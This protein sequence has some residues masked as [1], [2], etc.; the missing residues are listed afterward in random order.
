MHKD[1]KEY[2]TKEKHEALSKELDNLRTKGRK[3]IAEALE[4]AKS[5]G[6]LSENAE[7]QEARATQAEI[8]ERIAKLESILKEAVIVKAHKSDV[9]EIGVT[10]TVQKESG[11]KTKYQIVG[12][13]ESNTKEGKISNRSPIGEAIMGKKEGDSFTFKTP[14]G[15]VKYKIVDIA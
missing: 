7:Y 13:E 3:E 1:G 12:S 6:D 5:L 15:E 14:K 11:E 10:V 4:Y 8:E 2:L 9:V